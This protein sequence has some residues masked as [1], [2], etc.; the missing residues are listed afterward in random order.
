MLPEFDIFARLERAVLASHTE[1][2]WNWVT[3]PKLSAMSQIWGKPIFIMPFDSQCGWMSTNE[4]LQFNSATHC[5]PH[6]H[7][8]SL[9]SSVSRLCHAFRAQLFGLS[10][11]R[12][13]PL[14]LCLQISIL[15]IFLQHVINWMHVLSAQPCAEHFTWNASV[16]PR[17]EV[18]EGAG[19]LSL[20]L[21]RERLEKLLPSSSHWVSG[22]A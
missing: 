6:H 16:N 17:P 22:R 11:P 14:W 13:S 21:D 12:G 7:S 20:L 4:Y 18:R 3:F 9:L 15:F 2:S 10:S 19:G 8:V 1:R 5:L